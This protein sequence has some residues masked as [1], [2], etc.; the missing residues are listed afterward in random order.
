MSEPLR[1][2]ETYLAEHGYEIKRITVAW[3]R[4]SNGTYTVWATPD[5][6][7]LSYTSRVG[8]MELRLRHEC[9]TS[10]A[11]VM[12]AGLS[13]IGPAVTRLANKDFFGIDE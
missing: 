13:V 5:K 2:L 7:T 12:L 1:K 10:R 8:H 6:T 3:F 4:A 11:A 9:K